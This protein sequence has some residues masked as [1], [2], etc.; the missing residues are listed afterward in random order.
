MVDIK[1]VVDEAMCAFRNGGCPNAAVSCILNALAQ[2]E[3]DTI[4]DY[5]KAKMAIAEIYKD[6]ENICGAL[7]KM[8]NEIIQDE[9][10]HDASFKKASAIISGYNPAKPEEYNKAVKQNDT[11]GV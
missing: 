11:A 10:D 1:W 5:E 3:T 9:G 4:A 7:V 6:K 8:I 2:S